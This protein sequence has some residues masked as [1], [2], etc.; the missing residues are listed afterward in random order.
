M[1]ITGLRTRR[2][3]IPFE[4]PIGTSIHR[5]EGV[6]G[7]LVWLDTDE[8]ITGESYLWA[9][10]QHRLPVLDAIVRMLG[11]RQIGRDPRDT[12]AR[13]DEMWGEINF[14]GHKGVSL[15][16][17]AAIDWACWDILGQSLG[18]SVSRLLGRRRDRVRAY[19]S[20]GLWASMTIDALQVQAKDF[21]AQGF[22]AVKMRIGKPDIG[23]DIERVAAVRDAIGPDIDLMADANQGLSVT[24]AIRLGRRLEEFGLVWFEEPVQAYDLEGSARVAAEIDTP[25]ASGETEYGRYGFRD[26]LERKS[27]DVLMPD[28]ERVGGVTEWVRVA[29]MAAAHDVPV[30]PHIFSEHSLQL[31]GAVSNVTYSEHMP[32]FAPLFQE[33]M[34]M[35]NG[36]ILIPDR[37]GFGFHFD[38]DAIGRYALA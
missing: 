35:A 29:A 23:E 8:G 33:G 30:S 26:M 24:H 1:K 12:T 27:A 16:G 2:V 11:E 36:D 7:L 4:V 25:I 19:A 6:S 10:G 32:W 15:F 20:G 13:F 18:V 21:V 3:H 28:L 34:E 22:K 38:P 9:I 37:P 31:C 17:I 5:I 14:L